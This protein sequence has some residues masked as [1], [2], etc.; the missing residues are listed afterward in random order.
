M[1]Q[2]GMPEYIP[3]PGLTH[4]P[5]MPPQAIPHGIMPQQFPQP[6]VSKLHI[7]IYIYIYIYIDDGLGAPLSIYRGLRSSTSS[8]ASS[9]E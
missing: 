6:P 5:Y 4:Q 7:Y 8:T 1:N 3:N 2:G 9:S